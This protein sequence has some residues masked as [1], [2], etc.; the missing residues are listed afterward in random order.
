MDQDGSRWIKMDQDG[1]IVDQ[2]GSRWIDSEPRNFG[3]GA[4]V[5]LSWGVGGLIEL[6]MI[7]ERHG[8]GCECDE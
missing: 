8:C 2:D 6:I 1:S 3:S 4:P 7:T 5:F